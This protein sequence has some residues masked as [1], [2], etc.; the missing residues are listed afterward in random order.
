MRR[1]LTA[2]HLWLGITIGLLWALQGLGGAL[3]AF[4][5]DMQRLEGPA[6]STGPMAPLD[7]IADQAGK[8]SQ[9]PIERIG[10]ADERGDLLVA[11]YRD[12]DGARRAKL[13]DAARG[14][15]VGDRDLEPG[16]PFGS[17]FWGWLYHFHEALGG[18]RAL[19]LVVGVS[20][21]FLLTALVVGL[22]VGWPRRG[23][24]RAAFAAAR[25]RTRDQKLYGWHRALGLAAGL[26]LL[27]AASTG[28]YLIFASDLR[29]LIAQVVPHSPPYSVDSAA[30]P[31][32]SGDIGP[33]A[34][35]HRAQA[36]FPSAAFVSVTMP[37][38]RS[39]AYTV[40]L[41]QPEE[42]RS[43]SG[44]TSVTID[45]SGRVLAQYDAVS[46]P[47]SN[48]IGDA[49][50]AI[51]SG[52]IFGTIGRFLVLLLGLALPTLYAMG[53]W[54]W[55]RRAKRRRARK[56]PKTAAMRGEIQ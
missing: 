51:H 27:I 36:L 28:I 38:A 30:A 25:W 8:A 10:V 46:A 49:I 56:Q 48:R 53:I 11:E 55:L 1:K 21:L 45:K 7:R 34:A 31:A 43:W 50:F 3:L 19:E 6:V 47:L 37:T 23:A 35:Y 29:P 41:R 33:Q 2:F 16:S 44:V 32:G 5:R 14:E 42:L 54:V 13:V 15:T 12:Q 24:W 4:H 26:P 40:R 39:P 20:G 17:N 9:R 22:W 18:G 52:E